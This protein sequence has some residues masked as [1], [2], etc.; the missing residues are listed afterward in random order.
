MTTAALAEIHAES[1]I[2]SFGGFATHVTEAAS[3]LMCGG[4]TTEEVFLWFERKQKLGRFA[5]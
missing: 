1:E 5:E 4:M 2:V 3:T